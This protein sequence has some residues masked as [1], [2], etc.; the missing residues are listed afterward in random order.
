MM[1]SFLLIIS[2]AAMF[3]FIIW[4][5]DSF[6]WYRKGKMVVRRRIFPVRV[7]GKLVWFKKVYIYKDLSAF[8]LGGS[9]K[10]SVKNNG[11]FLMF[12]SN[13]QGKTSCSYFTEFE[14]DSLSEFKR[15]YKAGGFFKNQYREKIETQERIKKNRAFF[16]RMGINLD[17]KGFVRK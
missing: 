5:T 10:V 6:G 8:S 13:G 14:A 9:S 11:R 1:Y 12:T 2:L 7:Q 16:L 17:E 3:V 4:M 15:L